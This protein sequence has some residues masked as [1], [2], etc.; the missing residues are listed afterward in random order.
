M[1]HCTLR[2]L[3]SEVVDWRVSNQLSFNWCREGFSMR[4]RIVERPQP[5]N[6]LDPGPWLNKLVTVSVGTEE[7][8][9]GLFRLHSQFMGDGDGGLTAEEIAQKYYGYLAHRPAQDRN[10]E[11]P[12]A[13]CVVLDRE[14]FGTLSRF[15]LDSCNHSR[16]VGVEFTLHGKALDRFTPIASGGI[17]WGVTIK[18]A[19]IDG[20][21]TLFVAEFRFFDGG[22]KAR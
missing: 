12:V 9:I 20:D 11:N 16:T 14:K 19:A 4:G 15:S 17:Y 1:N 18:D 10:R 13:V 3:L 21:L 5:F 8:V 22:P 6:Q 7:D 2:V